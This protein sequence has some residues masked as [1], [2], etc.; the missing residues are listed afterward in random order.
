[1]TTI[2]CFVCFLFSEMR[3]ENVMFSEVLWVFVFLVICEM[4]YFLKLC[5]ILFSVMFLCFRKCC[6]D[7]GFAAVLRTFESQPFYSY[8]PH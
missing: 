3:F 4:L 1:V 2:L 8:S 5:E 6:F 7:Y